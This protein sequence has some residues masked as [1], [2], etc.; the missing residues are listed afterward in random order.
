[1]IVAEEIMYYSTKLLA[2]GLLVVTTCPSVIAAETVDAVLDNAENALGGHAVLADVQ[3]VRIRS[4]GL[5]QMPSLG[6]P[7]T[8]FQAEVVFRRPDRVR[9]AWKFPV[10]LGGDFTFGYD[11][12][13]TWMIWGAPPARSK[14]WL[15]E[16]VRQRW[17]HPRPMR[18]PR[19][20]R[21]A[22]NHLRLLIP[23]VSGSSMTRA[24]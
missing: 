19:W 11:G 17:K 5:W 20:S 14:G 10:E 1:V 15:R 7:P 6:I 18:I 2:V 23:G 13:D 3:A 4:H 24:S 8:P 22:T 9:L 12:Q 16:V 21:S